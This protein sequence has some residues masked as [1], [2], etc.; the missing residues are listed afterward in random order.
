MFLL[1]QIQYR[2]ES[3]YM[4]SAGHKSTV[5]QQKTYRA[6]RF[7]KQL[8]SLQR[9]KTILARTEGRIFLYFFE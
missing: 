9:N 1:V 3:G 8:V 4:Q 6:N 5:G 7:M 2:T